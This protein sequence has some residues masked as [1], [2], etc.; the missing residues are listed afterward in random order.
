MFKKML[1]ISL[2]ILGSGSTISAQNAPV[3]F[4]KSIVSIDAGTVINAPNASRWNRTILLA[5]PRI[6]SGEVGQLSDGIRQAA[7]MFVLSIA[8]TVDQDPQA[9]DSRFRLAEVGVGYSV[10]VANQLTVLRSN[11]YAAYGVDLSFIHRQM[12]SENERQIGNIKTVVRA[13][14]LLMFDVSA[15]LLQNNKH[16]DFTMRHLIWI[17]TRTGKLA[18]MVWLLQADR[19]KRLSVVSSEPIRWLEPNTMEDRAIHVD[20][21]EFTVGIPSKRAFAL[22]AMPPGRP[23]AWTRAAA[24][25]AALESYD[26]NNIQE[27]LKALNEANQASQAAKP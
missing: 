21:A 10:P 23:I 20:G 5:K 19:E 12:L 11:N 7:S 9:T 13:N 3:S 24:T 26:I 27:L 16:V 18:T 1:L 22:E 4:A 14:S 8:A 25:L 17:D 15:I 6:A 2:W